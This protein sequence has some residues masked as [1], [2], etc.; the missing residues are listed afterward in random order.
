MAGV[1]AL[2]ILKPIRVGQQGWQIQRAG[3]AEPK[4][5]VGGG[6]NVNQEGV[7]APSIPGVARQTNRQI[8]PWPW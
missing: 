3:V 1:K 4:V 8:L 6:G 5:P 2:V 7:H